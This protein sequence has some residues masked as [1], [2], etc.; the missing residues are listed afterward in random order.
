MRL[1]LLGCIA[2]FALIFILA[3]IKS[4][5]TNRQATRRRFQKNVSPTSSTPEEIN[6]PLVQD[7][8]YEKPKLVS[9]SPS[10]EESLT[11]M[12]KIEY[13][14]MHVMAPQGERFG[15][16][17]L[18][19]TLL[20]C[21]LRLGRDKIFHRFC[22]ASWQEKYFSLTSVNRP[23]TFDL[24]NMNQFSCPGLSLFMVVEDCLQP[25][26]SF[27]ILYQTAKHLADDL[28]GE[29]WRENREPLT[30]SAANRIR[31][32]LEQQMTMLCAE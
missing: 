3:A 17:R 31:Q 28:G 5:H 1:F 12:P 27:D 21:G 32:Q 14:I 13:I 29:I 20:S 11:S 30:D 4:N 26:Q 2:L 7:Q 22:N 8:S 6:A 23:G 16:Y 10:V 25:L 15:G 18:L 9:S 19:Q 24:P